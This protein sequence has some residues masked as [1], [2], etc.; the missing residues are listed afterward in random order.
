MTDS[1][2]SGREVAEAE[3]EAALDAWF[4]RPDWREVYAEGPPVRAYMRH[5]LEA[6]R[7]SV[8]PSPDV[9]GLRREVERLE[10]QAAEKEWVYNEQ[11]DKLAAAEARAD[12]AARVLQDCRPYVAHHAGSIAWG[13]SVDLLKR[14]DL[15]LAPPRPSGAE[16]D[17]T[18]T[19]AGSAS[20]DRG[21][22]S[23]AGGTP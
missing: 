14:L 4:T 15:A 2:E 7:S 17:K 20:D 3:V 11:A 13:G 16:V 9:E 6:A 1:V 23:A 21:I 22:V 8:D 10:R 5:A 18:P 19:G 12:A